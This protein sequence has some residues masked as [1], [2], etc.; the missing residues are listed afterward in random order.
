MK[1]TTP[2][3]AEISLP[4]AD[5]DRLDFSSANTQYI[6]DLEPES[7]EYVSY[8]GGKDQPA[9]LVEFYKPRRDVAFDLNP[10]RLDGKTFDKGLSMHARTKAVYRL[11]GKFV[12]FST[13]AGID[14]SVRDAGDA[15][16]EIRGDGKMLWEAVVRGTDRAQLVD[17]SVAGVRRLEIL[18]DFG[19]GFDAGDVIDLCDA[20]VNR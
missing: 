15:R 12:R 17:V 8:F 6:S 11:P 5:L 10:L 1:V 20:K 19:G 18:A 2:A 7:F 16:L 14:D 9:T 13:V 4:L 3:G